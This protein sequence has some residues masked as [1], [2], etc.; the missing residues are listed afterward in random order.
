MRGGQELE[1]MPSWL[2]EDFIP[3]ERQAIDAS[4]EERTAR[5]AEYTAYHVGQISRNLNR[6]TL[7]LDE[8]AVTLSLLS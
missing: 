4:S 7:L 1:A 3:L 6:I 8:V 5:A 2:N